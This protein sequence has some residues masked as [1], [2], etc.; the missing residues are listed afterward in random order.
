MWESI[1][2]VAKRE[3]ISKSTL[4]NQAHMVPPPPYYKWIKGAG[5]QKMLIETDDSLWKAWLEDY[6]IKKGFKQLDNEQLKNLVNA[7]YEVIKE[8]YDPSQERMD[9]L[10]KKINMKF[11]G[12]E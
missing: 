10:L 12:Y 7:V 4:Y 5:K 8:V 3:R 6:R 9:A 2:K 1:Y 11:Q